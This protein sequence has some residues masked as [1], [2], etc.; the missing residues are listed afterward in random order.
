MLSLVVTQPAIVTTES[1]SLTPVC[2]RATD[3]MQA[4]LTLAERQFIVRNELDGLRAQRDLRIPGLPDNYT[5]HH[6][7][8][9]CE[10][11]LMFSPFLLLLVVDGGV[12]SFQRLCC[13]GLALA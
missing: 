13:G 2:L 10:T 7:D 8:N 5:L 6:R 1:R 11:R 3:N 4:F 9:I 12:V